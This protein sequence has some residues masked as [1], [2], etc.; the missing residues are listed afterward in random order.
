MKPYCFYFIIIV[1]VSIIVIVIVS[2]FVSIIVSIVIVIVI[3]SILK[4][5]AHGRNALKGLNSQTAFK[6]ITIQG[7]KQGQVKAC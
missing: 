7:R 4:N 6:K 5:H 2:I 1:I 3:V